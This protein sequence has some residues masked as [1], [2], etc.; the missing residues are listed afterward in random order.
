MRDVLRRYVRGETPL[1]RVFFYDMLLIGTI[2]NVMADGFSLM[3][4]AT[5]LPGWLGWAIFLSLLIYS[6]ALC[7]F[8]WRSAASTSS[9]W[10]D[11]A[12]AG[13]AIWFMA[14]TVT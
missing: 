14:V 12:R 3:A 7:I 2:V 4:Y 8:V 13:S 5:N 11:W 10:G 6:L 9:S 1:S